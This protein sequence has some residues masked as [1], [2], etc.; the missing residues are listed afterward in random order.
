[1]SAEKLQAV[2][3]L[4]IVDDDFKGRLLADAP[5]AIDAEPRLAVASTD[6]FATEMAALSSMSSADFEEL[7]KLKAQLPHDLVA[8][9]GGVIL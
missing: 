3:A 4:A 8:H 6:L 7:G 1:M 2:V 5:A 9:T